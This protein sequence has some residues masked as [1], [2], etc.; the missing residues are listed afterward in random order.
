MAAEVSVWRHAGGRPHGEGKGGHL[1]AACSP[2]F[3]APGSRLDESKTLT[4]C[5]G[6]LAT[7]PRLPFVQYCNQ[8]AFTADALPAHKCG[9]EKES[10]SSV[11]TVS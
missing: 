11:G 10:N 7:Q 1:W 6:K 5:R 3:R 2:E 9:F 4:T 8:I